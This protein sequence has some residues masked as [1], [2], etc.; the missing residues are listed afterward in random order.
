[1]SQERSQPER[2]QFDEPVRKHAPRIAKPAPKI[3]IVQTGT[4]GQLAEAHG[5]YPAWFQAA[6]PSIDATPILRADRGEKLSPESLAAHGADGIIV[7]GSPLSMTT[8]EPWMIDLGG[9]LLRAGERGVPVLGVCFGHQLLSHA[10]GAQVILNPRGREIGTVELQLTEAGARDPLFAYARE[11][12]FTGRIEVQASHVDAVYPIPAGATLLA[13]N[14][15]TPVQALRFSE[16]VASVQFH[17]E[18]RTGTLRDL[19]AS[20]REAIERAGLDA[21]RLIATVRETG[22]S[23]ILRAFAEQVR[24]A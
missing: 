14:E 6:L 13:S 10:S 21:A 2:S 8:P 18:L 9:E 20:R 24:H 4:A 5:D 7:T 3:L 15:Q 11:T 22:S 16:T 12:E 23:A 17:P 19:I 1:V